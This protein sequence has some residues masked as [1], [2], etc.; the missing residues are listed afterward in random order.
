MLQS[1]TRQIA[2]QEGGEMMRKT[3]LRIGIVSVRAMPDSSF[4]LRYRDPETGSDVRRVL[5]GVRIDEAKVMA[6]HI[7]QQA[8]VEWGYRPG[9][10]R[11]TGPS[12]RDALLETIRLSRQRESTRRGSV[13]SANMFLKWAAQRFPHLEMFSEMKPFVL[14]EYA[15]YMEGRGL[16]ANSIRNR[17]A[18]VRAAWRWVATNYP[19]AGL[20]LLP[21]MKTGGRPMQRATMSAAHLHESLEWLRSRDPDLYAVGCLTALAGLRQTEAFH[22]RRQ[23]IDFARGL[24][25]VCDT[26]KHRLKTPCSERIIPVTQE[27]L[28]ALQSCIARQRVI[29]V[30]G[31]LFPHAEGWAAHTIST[32]WRR[33][34]RRAAEEAGIQ[35]IGR[36]PCRRFRS[37][38]ATMAFRLGVH[39][40]VLRAYLGHTPGDMLNAHYKVIGLGDLRTVPDAMTNWRTLCQED[41][42]G[43]NLAVENWG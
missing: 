37:V 38:F 29:P 21:T 7:S 30:D 43:R 42:S 39:D 12:L 36:F 34:L 41:D 18:P 4:T 3:V 33:A 20:P 24:V 10:K 25:R 32:K 40:S 6:A 19:E 16:A 9:R 27:V 26:E 23:D 22:L 35:E 31:M 15:R 14:T 17:L 1:S 13:E 5:R 11:A 28:E 2:P 8:Q